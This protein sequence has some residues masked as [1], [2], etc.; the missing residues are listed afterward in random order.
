VLYQLNEKG[1]CPVCK[2]KP[3]IY[4]RQGKYFCHRC[5]RVYSMSTKKQIR[6]FFYDN[7]G[8]RTRD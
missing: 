2:I 5:D 7:N 1:Q 3:I 8:I 6:S 4:K